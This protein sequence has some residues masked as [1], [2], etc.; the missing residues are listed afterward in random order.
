M[1]F[2]IIAVLVFLAIAWLLFAPQMGIVSV[3]REH[4]R[5]ETVQQK[6]SELEK[7]NEA[8]RQEIERITNDVEYLERLAREKH[9]L[10]KKNEMVF[11]FDKEKSGE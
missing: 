8:L 3:Y 5:L 9:G 1:L 11:D 7:E 2:R 10:L 4:K 6:K